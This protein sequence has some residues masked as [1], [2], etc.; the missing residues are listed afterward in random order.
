MNVEDTRNGVAE[1]IIDKYGGKVIL[2]LKWGQGA[3]DIGGE[4]QVTSLE[5]AM[6]PE[7][8]GYLVDPDPITPWF[9]PHLKQG[10]HVLC[11]AQPAGVH[12][13]F[14]PG[15]GSRTFMKAIAYFGA[16]V[17]AG[18]PSKPVPMAWKAWPWPSDMPRMP[19][20]TC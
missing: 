2:E 6:F 1:Y 3:K 19:S 11:P 9:R 8:P 20:S 15:C 4:I 13:P 16:S 18:S 7:R 12:R 10:D 14:Y 5:Y 17:P